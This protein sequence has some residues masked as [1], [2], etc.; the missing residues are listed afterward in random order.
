MPSKK[1]QASSSIPA[2]RIVQRT[3]D[4][5]VHSGPP[6]IDD[7]GN[8]RRATTFPINVASSAH[9]KRSSIPHVPIT[10]ARIVPP[11]T[12]ASTSHIVLDAYM[13]SSSD[14]IGMQSPESQ[15]SGKVGS[16][17]FGQQPHNSHGLPDF[18][19]V[20]FPSGDP[21][22]YPNQSV[23]SLEDHQYIKSAPLFNS[24]NSDSMYSFT[25]TS[26]TAPYDNSAVQLF[27]PLPPYLLQGQPYGMGTQS[28]DPRMELD[29]TDGEADMIGMNDGIGGWPPQQPV[30]PA[31]MNLDDI[32][33]EEWKAGWFDQG[34]AQ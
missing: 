14:T 30:K 1:R 15:R 7:A 26:S 21:F 5:T 19:A 4:L 2:T 23:M 11:N 6:S 16:C 29:G 28:I 25:P 13:P 27:G 9:R 32:F 18:S 8:V 3:P 20:M 10:S 31:G 33:G 17:V 12:D 22:A 24:S 34:F